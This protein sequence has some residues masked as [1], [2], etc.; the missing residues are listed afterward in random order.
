MQVIG[1]AIAHALETW[2][3]NARGGR[4]GHGLARLA[5]DLKAGVRPGSGGRA[6]RRARRA[7]C[8]TCL[9]RAGLRLPWVCS[10][11][12]SSE[13]RLCSKFATQ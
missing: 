8:F 1:G 7:P 2:L 4:G 3:L 9:L 13:K 12:T 11:P 10:L 5:K 6:A